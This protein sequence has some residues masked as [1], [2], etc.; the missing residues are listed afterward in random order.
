MLPS[1]DCCGRLKVRL[2][3]SHHHQ[4]T[5]PDLTAFCIQSANPL[6]DPFSAEC[7]I[8]LF[9]SVCFL[10]VCSKKLM[11]LSWLGERCLPG[12]SNKLAAA[13]KTDGRALHSAVSKA[14]KQWKNSYGH[15]TL[16]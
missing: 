3:D 10:R 4:L 14:R 9:L 13:L 8:I 2:S 12:L 1:A 11:E 16:C 15:S 6:Q 5:Y 7:G